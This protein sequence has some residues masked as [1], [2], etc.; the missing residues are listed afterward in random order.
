MSKIK[1]WLGVAL[2]VWIAMIIINAITTAVAKVSTS[3]AAFIS[4]P[5]GAIFVMLGNGNG[6]QNG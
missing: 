4:N 2:E 3:A 1:Y 5:V 6:S